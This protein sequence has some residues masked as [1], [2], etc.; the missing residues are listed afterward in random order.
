MTRKLFLNSR[1]KPKKVNQEQVSPQQS[2]QQ[3]PLFSDLNQNLQALQSIYENCYDVVFRRFTIGEGTKA[4][5]I[6]MDGLSNIAELDEN[7]L[8][9]LMREKMDDKSGFDQILEKILSVSSVNKIKTIFDVIENIP[10]GNPVLLIE[11]EDHGLAIGLP[12]WEHR[13][14]EEPAAELILRGPR[15][16]F[17]ETLSVNTAQ[18]RRIIQVPE[19]KMEPIKIGRYTRTN[20]VIA[21]IEGLTDK[22][23]V[24]EVKNRLQ[25]I[26]NDGILSAGNVEELIED[27]PSSPFP[28]ILSTERP[29]VVSSNLLE[30]RVAIMLNNTPIVLVA[31]TTFFSLLQA[32][33]DYSQRFWIGTAIRWLRY[34]FLGVSLLLPSA[35]VAVLTFHQE[36]I[37]TNLLLTVA[38]SREGIPFP[39]LVEALLMEVSFEALR[40]AG[41]RL[42]KQIGAA[43]S[44]VGALVIG[45]A[46]VSAGLASAPMVMVVAITGIA[47]F[48][49]PRYVAGLTIRLL[50]FPIILLSGSLGLFG[51][52]LGVIG[53][54]IHLCS[55]RSFGVPYLSPL[56]PLKTSDLKDVLVRSPLWKMDTRPH[57][58]G[59]YN[60]YRQ[61]PGQKP[62]QDNGGE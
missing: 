47:S 49:I 28:Q 22:N 20:I 27:N 19:L 21:Y 9:P 50:R 39:A 35:Y 55:L 60:K 36:M 4:A 53:I 54:A 6:Y 14:I 18:L 7:V 5:L 12:K 24:E 40:E 43:V 2:N 33:D 46:A 52:M 11:G 51:L 8:A 61:A 62:G 3:I 44:I 23:L 16:G 26:D 13:G 45:Q 15:E 10:M 57:L 1:K 59:E 30:G 31:P 17:T 29:D 56:A 42:P 34:L 25:R 41:V 58:T 38:A 37:P 32:P 48:M